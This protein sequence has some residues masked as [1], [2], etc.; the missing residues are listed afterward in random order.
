MD[1]SGDGRD[2]TQDYLALGTQGLSLMMYPPLG[3]V[4]Y[5]DLGGGSVVAAELGRRADHHV[6]AGGDFLHGHPEFM[7]G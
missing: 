4:H 1:I 7:M 3:K 6:R 2:V 5:E